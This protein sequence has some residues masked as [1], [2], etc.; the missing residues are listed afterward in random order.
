[1][2]A[3]ALHRQVTGAGRPGWQPR[4]AK[5]FTEAPGDGVKAARRCDVLTSRRA[6][7]AARWGALSMPFYTQ[8]GD[9]AHPGRHAQHPSAWTPGTLPCTR[10]QWHPCQV[11]KAWSTVAHK[12]PGSHSTKA[13]A[14]G[15]ACQLQV[16]AQKSARS[17]TPTLTSGWL[18]PLQTDLCQILPQ[19]CWAVRA[20]AGAVK[21]AAMRLVSA[22]QSAGSPTLY[23]HSALL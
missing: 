2:L 23:S 5:A 4:R 10:R 17:P 7:C 15:V 12:V 16:C 8:C 1:M 20:Q 9:D 11:V 6:A 22:Q 3:S 21:G 19:R 13:A 18:W 14:T